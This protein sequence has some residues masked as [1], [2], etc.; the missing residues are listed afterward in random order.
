[1]TTAVRSAAILVAAGLLLLTGGPSPA[2]AATLTP[3]CQF[4]GQNGYYTTA[5]LIQGNDGN[6]YG[7]TAGGGS[8]SVGTIFKISTQGTLTTLWQFSGGVDG[9]NPEAGLLQGLD[10]NL[11][12]TA[13]DGGASTNCTG[14][15]GTV[16]KI[17]P[18]GT[19]TTLLSF[20]RGAGGAY[21]QSGFVQGSDSNFYGTA[22]FGG[23]NSV[24]TVFKITP[25]GTL[26]SLWQFSGGADGS[27]PEVGLVPGGDGNFYGTTFTGGSN[28]VGTAF[29]ITPQGK[30]TVLWQFS[31]EI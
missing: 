18:Q 20:N 8:N 2:L 26:T 21:P 12:G 22:S 27:N 9:A 5:A 7:T 17:T 23:S 14:G 31:G 19:L 10:G 11:Y 28:N 30:L 24:G 3:L 15:C 13:Y 4:N 29:K 16:F 1:M 25:Q 6:F